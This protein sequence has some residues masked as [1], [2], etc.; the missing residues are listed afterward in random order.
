M[1]EN[2]KIKVI[3]VCL[4]NICRSPMAEAVFQNVV[5]KEGLEEHF[6][7]ASSGTSSYHVGERP[8]PGTRAILKQYGIEI[9]PVKRAQKLPPDELKEYDYVVAMDSENA[10]D[11]KRLGVKAHRLLDFAPEGNPL[12]VPDPYYTN[13][14]EDVYR[15]V[16]AGARGLFEQVRI[17]EGL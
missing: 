16:E 14:F 11:L 2:H 8:H 5:K 4:G 9:D 7:I 6:E 10:S 13:R 3:F 1:G 15:L 17:K 12:D